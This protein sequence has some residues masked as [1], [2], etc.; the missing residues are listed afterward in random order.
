MKGGDC[1]MPL[2][3]TI[4]IP[5]RNE[6]KNLSGCLTAIGNN[7][8]KEVVVID[9]GSVDRTKEIALQHGARV[10]SFFWNGKFPKK[11][12]WYLRNHTPKTKWVLFLDADEYLTDEFKLALCKELNTP[13][14]DKV[15]YWLNYTIYFL[16]KRLR[17][18][19]PLDKLALF[20][21]KKGEY[22]K[23]EEDQWSN[24]DM[25]IHEHPV[26]EGEIGTIKAKIEHQDFRGMFHYLT[27]H[28]EYSSWEAL[29]FLQKSHDSKIFSQWTWKQKI[30][31]RLASNPWIGP[32]FFIGSFFFM[33]G[34]RDGSRGFIFAIL[35]MAYFTE[36][37]CK[38]QELEHNYKLRKK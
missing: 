10:I 13:E 37:Y 29:R 4:A 12:N 35:K 21:V 2:D 19:Y 7:L 14:V 36:V 9:S 1:N 16:G 25:E 22:E 32:I 18:G 27:K 34:F 6:E 38:I 24:F 20:Q 30:K 31:Y 5:V 11:R 17:G 26:L 28:N 8:A 15:G 23:I 33:G 3:L